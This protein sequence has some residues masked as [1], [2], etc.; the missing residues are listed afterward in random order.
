MKSIFLHFENIISGALPF[1]LLMVCGVVLTV[2]G[3]LFQLRLFPRSLILTVR[4]FK[5]RKECNGRL[6]SIQ[7]ACTALSATVGTGNI[8]GVAGA[9]SIGGAGAV[10]W[11]WISALLGMAVKYAEIVLAVRFR[12]E[13]KGEFVGGPMYY[14]KNGIKGASAFGT[15]FAIAAIP[16]VFCSGNITQANA[17]VSAVSDNFVVRLMFSVIFALLTFVVI[18]GG[19]TQ[20]G[21][22]SEKII[23]VMTVMYT[24]MSLSV[25]IVNYELVPK[26]FEL[27]IKGAFT[28]KAV[29][30]G[31]VGSVFTSAFIGASRGVFS[32][33]AGLGTSAMAHSAAYDADESTQGLYGIF[34]VF[35]D[36]ILICTLTALTILC[37]SVKI[38]YGKAASTE[39][40]IRSLST[41]YGNFAH[42]IL[43][44][45]MCFFAF[46]SIIGWALYGDI[47]IG[48]LSGER[49]KKLFK[50]IYPLGCIAGGVFSISAA[51][52]LSAF[53]NGI[54]L[55]INL[56]SVMFL[57]KR[58]MDNEK[59]DRK[60]KKIS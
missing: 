59:K 40:V 54:M 30:G 25:V 20:I 36:T 43:A 22:V 18:K 45:M 2:G 41:V 34:E 24:L 51:W 5:E 1:A 48:F 58:R 57:Y 46:S 7:S 12:E 53:F 38:D 39:L 28:P 10:F 35:I 16:A 15:I 42:P 37:G 29:T 14:I 13:K 19:V 33:E 50:L 56:P 31:A 6:S 8:A 3:R 44:S 55:C 17:A 32:N 11:M 9:I 27:I 47:C 52:R 49:A 23:P 21:I 26:A 4:T 60:H